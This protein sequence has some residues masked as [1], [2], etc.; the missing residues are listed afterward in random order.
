MCVLVGQFTESCTLN[1]CV[2]FYLL[3]MMN[4]SGRTLQLPDGLVQ[5]RESDRTSFTFICSI[6]SIFL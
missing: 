1:R 3:L 4:F 2:K 6:S 5:R